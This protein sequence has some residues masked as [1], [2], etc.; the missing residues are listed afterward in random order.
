MDEFPALGLS[1]IA[2]W[3]K[4]MS[5]QYLHALRY[6]SLRHVSRA[7]KQSM[8]ADVSINRLPWN[9]LQLDALLSR[10]IL[11]FFT[12]NST[13]AS[14]AI[15]LHYICIIQLIVQANVLQS[16]EYSS[17][18]S[19]NQNFNHYNNTINVFLSYTYIRLQPY[20]VIRKPPADMANCLAMQIWAF[21]STRAAAPCL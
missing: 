12:R 14:T 7:D 1:F 13:S 8:H 9:N 2:F 15:F 4:E 11:K 19:K 20:D 5:R 10:V 6:S 21:V 17:E 3:C 16:N 18:W